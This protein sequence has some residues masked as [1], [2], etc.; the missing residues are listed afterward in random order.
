MK[1]TQD[2]IP[3]DAPRGDVDDLI[4]PQDTGWHVSDR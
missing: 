3:A 2:T 4:F 1:E